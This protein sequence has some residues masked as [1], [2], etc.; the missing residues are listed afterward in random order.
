[1]VFTDVHS[2]SAVCSPSRYSLLTGRYNWRS[3]LLKGIVGLYVSPLMPTDR[4]TAP[5]FLS[6]HGY[7]TVCIGK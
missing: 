1:M 5:K 7:H 6:Q 2:C 3:T 4:L